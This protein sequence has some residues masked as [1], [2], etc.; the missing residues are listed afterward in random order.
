MKGTVS[1]TGFQSLDLLTVAKVGSSV[2]LSIEQIK[3]KKT[4]TTLFI[5]WKD[6]YV[7][8]HM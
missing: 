5:Y 1:V 3:K 6:T 8:I 7:M 4:T 2:S